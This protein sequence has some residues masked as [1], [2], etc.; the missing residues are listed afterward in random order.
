VA[1]GAVS[2]A[3]TVDSATAFEV[4][5]TEPLKAWRRYRFAVEVQSGPPPGAPTVG[6]IP[7][8]EWSDASAAV[9][10]AVVP[11]EA[12]APPSAV[13]IANDGAILRITMTHPAADS[14]LATSM[15]TFTFE[16]WRANPGARPV[17]RRL[18][19]TRGPGA[20]WLAADSGAGSPGTYVTLRLIDPVGR[21]SDAVISNQLA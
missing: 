11:P 17:Q 15:G 9:P 18:V 3:T 14:L 10:L 20:T 5:A 8:G 2:G 21:R 12:P 6:V 19:F 16:C 1:Q 13:L 7:A 4:D